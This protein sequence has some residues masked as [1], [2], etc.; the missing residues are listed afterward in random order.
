MYIG[1]LSPEKGLLNLIDAMSRLPDSYELSLYGTGDPQYVNLLQDSVRDQD[2][3]GRVRFHGQAEGNGKDEAFFDAD[4]TVAPS[5]SENFGMSIAESLA[6]G[7]P[8]VASKA[9]PWEHLEPNGCGLW[10]DNDPASLAKA[11]VTLSR[12]PL[13]EMGVV[14]RH[15]MAREFQWRTI[16]QN[17]TAAYG[18]LVAS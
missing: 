13:A 17:M 7:V 5:F 18:Q 2:L 4:V 9:A 6:Y 8:V 16:A 15:W 14:A 10:V 1:R 3:S 11:I 12:R